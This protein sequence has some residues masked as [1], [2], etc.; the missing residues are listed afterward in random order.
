MKAKIKT[1][2]PRVNPMITA[3]TAFG[4]LDK[5]IHTKHTN[6]KDHNKSINDSIVRDYAYHLYEQNGCTDG[7]E[8]EDWLDAKA[9][10]ENNI[11]R[12]HSNDWIR[13]KTSI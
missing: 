1:H 2:N 5:K 11:P 6:L 10:I 13:T 8:V 7:R 12:E 3:L 4:I 9:C